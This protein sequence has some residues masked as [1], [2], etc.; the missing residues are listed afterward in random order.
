MKDKLLTTIHFLKLTFIVILSIGLGL[1]FI[2]AFIGAGWV[3]QEIFESEGISRNWG[4]LVAIFF[5]LYWLWL[6]GKESKT[7]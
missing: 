3:L 7:K 6:K 1:Y 4:T 2:A 5:P